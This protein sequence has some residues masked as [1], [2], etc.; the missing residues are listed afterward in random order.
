VNDPT[1][2]TL[3]GRCNTPGFAYGV[4]ISGNYAYVADY[5]SGLIIINIEDP[6]NP[7][8]VKN[9][10][11]GGHTYAVA[12]SGDYVYLGDNNNLVIFS[13]DSDN[14]G[15]VDIID[16]FPNDS[17]EW[18]DS[19][20]DGVGNNADSLPK[21]KLISSWNQFFVVLTLIS[22]FVAGATYSTVNYQNA[23]TVN[24]KMEELRIKIEE[25]KE[26]GIKTDELELILE[27]INN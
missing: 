16:F 9:Y 1:N 18:L 25:L 23:Q 22:I 15:F 3:V 24:K 7:T 5:D 11:V 20:G 12:I 27:K 6:A 17:T 14:D 13:L 2:P 19:D 10:Y 4:T 21:N 26:R 8:L